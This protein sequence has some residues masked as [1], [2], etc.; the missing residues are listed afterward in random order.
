MESENKA[1]I[2]K[3]DKQHSTTADGTSLGLAFGSVNAR[4]CLS[5]YG[6]TQLLAACLARAHV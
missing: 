3:E 1:M 4:T 6:A 5:A 2:Q